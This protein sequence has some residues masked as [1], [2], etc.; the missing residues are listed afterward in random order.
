VIARARI[1]TWLLTVALGL[2]GCG[3]IGADRVIDE[4]EDVVALL[5]CVPGDATPCL[6]LPRVV[7]LSVS[8]RAY[9]DEAVRRMRHA[10]HAQAEHFAVKARR[11]AEEA[12]RTHEGR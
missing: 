9:L 11:A 1:A 3:S 2:A 6:A 12:L 4:A 10:D 7:Y 8:A 5:P